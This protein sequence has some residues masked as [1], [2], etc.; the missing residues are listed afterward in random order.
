LCLF[1][2]GDGANATS[3]RELKNAEDRTRPQE[4]IRPRDLGNFGYARGF[5]DDRAETAC[6]L[7]IPATNVAWVSCLRSCDANWRMQARVIR[8]RWPPTATFDSNAN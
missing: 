6:E 2:C 3:L 4:K 1:Y 5:R 8:E 7:G